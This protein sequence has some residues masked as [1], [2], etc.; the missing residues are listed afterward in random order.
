MAWAFGRNGAAMETSAGRVFVTHVTPRSVNPPQRWAL[1]QCQTKRDR[2]ELKRRSIRGSMRSSGKPSADLLRKRRPAGAGNFSSH[3]CVIGLAVRS[4]HARSL[5][6]TDYR[7]HSRYHYGRI[8]TDRCFWRV[9]D[10]HQIL[11][12]SRV[13]AKLLR[14]V[15]R[16]AVSRSR[17][18]HA[19]TGCLGRLTT[20]DQWHPRQSLPRISFQRRRNVLVTGA[21]N[22][23]LSLETSA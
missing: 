11:F 1:A 6:L 7:F 14:S 19:L 9:Q 8:V 17:W 18:R 16:R 23:V 12:N 5:F 2:T 10:E 20:A 4:P 13:R 15:N 3:S 21:D 22:R